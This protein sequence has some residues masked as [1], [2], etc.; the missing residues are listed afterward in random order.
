MCDLSVI[1]V[2]Y[3]TRAMLK[4]CIESVYRNTKDL[5]FEV[6]V[7]DNNSAD[8]SQEMLA[9]E[10]PQVIK[11]L[12]RENRRWAGGN[13]QGIQ[14]A[15]GRAVVLLN[16]DTV[17][18][19]R[20][21]EKTTVF[22]NRTPEAAIVGCRLLNPDGTVQLSCNGFPSVWNLMEETF[23]LYKIFPNSEIFGHYYLNTFHYDHVERV[24]MASGAC[25]F[26]R[27]AIFE[28]VGLM[29]ESFSFY[30]EETDFCFRAKQLGIQTY[31]YPDAEVIHY[32]GA[33]QSNLQKRF[34]LLYRSIIHFVRKHFRGPERYC[35][36]GLKTLGVLLR[37]GVYFLTG[38]FT[39]DGNYVK[40]S[41]HYLKI[42]F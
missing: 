17:I 23:F 37:V 22:M 3:N 25:L 11:I 39:L 33:S 31:Y 12:N 30:G 4:A 13:N 14:S 1:I 24:D 2:S 41:L 34:D 5:D 7:V 38:I 40:K 18:G 28:K 15:S 16:S 42:L 6:I 26:I 10:F 35:M 29:D 21:L 8:G 20:A 27:R 36:I 19:E 32:G 9:V